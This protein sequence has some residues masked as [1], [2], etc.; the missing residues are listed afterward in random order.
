MPKFTTLRLSEPGRMLINQ[1]T[2]PS[3]RSWLLFQRRRGGSQFLFAETFG[4]W[5]VENAAKAFGGKV[6]INLSLDGGTVL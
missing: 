6:D 4:Q 1:C 2:A 3:V 5:R